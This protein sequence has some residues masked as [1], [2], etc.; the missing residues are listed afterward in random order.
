MKYS[1]L[2]FTLFGLMACK[3]AEDRRCV[4]S[5]GE[6][7]TISVSVD[8]FEKI[9]VG[10]NLNLVL[11]QDSLNEMRITGGENLVKFISSDVADGLLRIEN[12]NRCN[13]LRSYKHELTVEVHFTTLSEINFEGTKPLRCAS[14]ISGN[15]L[16]VFIRD[17]A[18]LVDLDVDYNNVNMTVTNGWGNFDISGLANSLNLNIR[19]NGFGTTYGLSVA[20]QVNVISNTAGLL[21]VNT[22][23]ADC[24]VQ[25]QSVGDVWYIGSPDSMDFTNLGEGQLV[26]KN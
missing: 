4:K 25:I 11:V 14:P 19:N 21:K 8:S 7:T 2:I 17:G 26:D 3:K 13:F 12:E 1:W 6:T 20:N 22:E 5:A 9:F 16:S 10:P 24:Q 15:N 18:G 23:G